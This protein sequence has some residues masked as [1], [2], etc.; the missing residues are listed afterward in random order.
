MRK[1]FRVDGFDVIFT[2]FMA[3]AYNEINKP[4]SAFYFL[5]EGRTL[6]FAEGPQLLAHVLGDAFL[7]AKNIDSA[8]FYYRRALKYA[9]E[10]P[11][12]VPNH[13]CRSSYELANLFN[14]QNQIDSS[15]YFARFAFRI[16]R[17]K[18]LNPRHP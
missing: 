6:P 9:I 5:R 16:A 18:R 1:K 13:I 15:F 14:M 2:I 12:F 4:D 17:E 3:R 10:N 7:Q 11:R 8:N